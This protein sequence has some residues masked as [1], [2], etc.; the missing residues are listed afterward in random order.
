MEKEKETEDEQENEEKEK[1]GGVGIK[2]KVKVKDQEPVNLEK[3][4][5][6]ENESSDEE[7]HDGK[8]DLN[9][10]RSIT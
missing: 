4:T 9:R 8:I 5:V 3:K 1:S 2:F 6:F 10:F 7:E